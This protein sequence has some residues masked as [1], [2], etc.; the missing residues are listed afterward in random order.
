MADNEDSTSFFKAA[1]PLLSELPNDLNLLVKLHPNLEH[2][3]DRMVEVYEIIGKYETK[4]NIVFLS[5]FPL[6]YPLLAAC[7]IYIEIALRWDYDFLAFNRPMFFFNESGRSE[8]KDREL[9][10]RCGRVIEPAE[11]ARFYEIMS[12][13]IP[14]DK[15]LYSKVREEIYQYTF[16]DREWHDVREDL[17][18]LF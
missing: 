10:Y 12:E 7:D 9:L 17:R 16:A 11:Y 8:K 15:G 2:D 3:H 5:E 1:E 4:P 18:S 13:M 6:I 14:K